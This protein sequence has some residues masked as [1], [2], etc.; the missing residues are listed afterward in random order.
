ML[1]AATR[2]VESNSETAADL[3][4]L[5]G[6]GTS[7]GGLRPNAPSSTTTAICLSASFQVS[8]TSVRHEGEVLALNLANAAGIAAAKA[9]LINSDGVPVALI[10]RFDRHVNGERAMYISAATMLGVERT[11]PM[12]I[13]IRRSWTSSACTAPKCKLISTSYGD[14]SHSPYSSQI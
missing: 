11:D 3:A 4:Y 1:F 13:P 2:A 14:A 5:R 7:L 8:W 6:R 12:S 10:R 9:R